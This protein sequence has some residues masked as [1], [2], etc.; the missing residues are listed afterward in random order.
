MTPMTRARTQRLVFFT[1]NEERATFQCGF[2]SDVTVGH[3]DLSGVEIEDHAQ[4]VR[5]RGLKE[6][7]GISRIKQKV[8]DTQVELSEHRI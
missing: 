6:N 2:T 8:T 1:Q 3:V 4:A 5:L 7:Q